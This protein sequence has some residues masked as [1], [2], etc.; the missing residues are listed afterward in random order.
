[1][2]AQH[3]FSSPMN[4]KTMDRLNAGAEKVH[5]STVPWRE[6]CDVGEPPRRRGCTVCKSPSSSSRPGYLQTNTHCRLWASFGSCQSRHGSY[7]QELA[8]L[9]TR[10]IEGILSWHQVPLPSTG[11]GVLR[12]G[13]DKESGSLQRHARF[14]SFITTQ[15]RDIQHRSGGKRLE[16]DRIHRIGGWRVATRHGGPPGQVRTPH[17]HLPDTTG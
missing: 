16:P 7:Y 6:P 4:N 14:L 1:M 8:P 17:R 12:L 11:L 3:S 15:T 9:P 2:V 10:Q 5:K 13:C